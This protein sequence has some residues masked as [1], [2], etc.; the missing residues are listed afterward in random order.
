MATDLH[1]K[2]AVAAATSANATALGQSRS[3]IRRQATRGMPFT[4]GRGD[5]DFTG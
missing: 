5:N 4:K 1:M 3:L 2:F